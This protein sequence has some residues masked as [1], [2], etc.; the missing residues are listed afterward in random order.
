MEWQGAERESVYVNEHLTKN[1]I[2]N[3]N[4]TVRLNPDALNIK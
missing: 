4:T 1:E 3:I 2:L